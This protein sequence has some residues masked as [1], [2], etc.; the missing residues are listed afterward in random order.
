[1]KCTGLL[2]KSLAQEHPTD[3][4]FHHFPPCLC[5]KDHRVCQLAGNFCSDSPDIH[6]VTQLAGLQLVQL[7]VRAY[8]CQINQ[9]Q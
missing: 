1:M 7:Y 5:P 9:I 3:G 2:G 4:S 8:S 6:S